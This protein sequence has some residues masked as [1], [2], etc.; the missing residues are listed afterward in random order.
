MVGDVLLKIVVNVCGFTNSMQIFRFMI[1][2]KVKVYGK[3][4]VGRL[5]STYEYFR[6]YFFVKYS[7]IIYKKL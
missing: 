7:P 3:L 2:Q 5:L 1:E 6:I 4:E